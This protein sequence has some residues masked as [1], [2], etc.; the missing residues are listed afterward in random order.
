MIFIAGKRLAKRGSLKRPRLLAGSLSRSL[1]TSCRRTTGCVMLD[2]DMPVLFRTA[3][4]LDREG[5]W[6]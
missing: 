2:D 5:G 6:P 4:K 3:V 1:A